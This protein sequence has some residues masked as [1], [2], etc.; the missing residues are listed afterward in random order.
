MLPTRLV[1]LPGLDGSGMLFAPLLRALPPDIAT[2]VVAYPE[3]KAL[4]YEDLLPAVFAALPRDAPF[5]LLGESFGGPLAIRVAARRPPGLRALILSASFISCPQPWLPLRS[6]A[7]LPLWPFRLFPALSRA[8]EML[9]AYP[10]PELGA[11]LRSALARVA[12]SV[13]AQRTRAVIAVDV[14]AELT[15]CELPMLYLQGR[16]DWM[17]PGAN[18]R[19]MLRIKPQLQ[20][21]AL[22]APHLLLQYQPQAAAA[23]I[24]GF[25]RSLP[26]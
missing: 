19:R 8:K 7:W 15:E 17:V 20:I 2:T 18:S 3:E 1:L 10:E 5:V 14:S 11:L 13:L 4:S 12:P 23:A 9:G 24:A 25:L 6:A 16:R 21:V 26:P 22:D